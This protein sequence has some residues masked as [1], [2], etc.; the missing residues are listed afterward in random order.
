MH[1][2]PPAQAKGAIPPSSQFVSDAG[3]LQR[4]L[5]RNRGQR[6]Q[7][8]AGS[9]DGAEVKGTDE[10]ADVEETGEGEEGGGEGRHAD[11]ASRS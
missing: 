3:N 1:L 8:V 4:D 10:G 2:S 7:R 5:A 9:G 11:T 6:P